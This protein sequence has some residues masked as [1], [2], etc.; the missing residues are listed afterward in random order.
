MKNFCVTLTPEV[1]SN[2]KICRFFCCC[3]SNSQAP[4]RVQRFPTFKLTCCRVLLPFGSMSLFFSCPE[5]KTN[6]EED[7][8]L[9]HQ[10]VCLS[11]DRKCPQNCGF[12]TKSPAKIINH[13][14]ECPNWEVICIWCM[15]DSYELPE[16]P[17]YASPPTPPPL[18]QQ[19]YVRRG[20]LEQHIQTHPREGKFF[21]PRPDLDLQIV[22]SRCGERGVFAEDY[23]EAQVSITDEPHFCWHERTETF[24]VPPLDPSKNPL[25]DAEGQAAPQND[26][27][28]FPSISS[29]SS[30]FQF[31]TRL[32][33]KLHSNIYL[34]AVLMLRWITVTCN[35]GHVFI[36][37]VLL[38]RT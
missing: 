23:R 18:P 36:R 37:G 14:Q 3:F 17:G 8:R 1:S 13:L 9:D 12:S 4:A 26:K 29:I 6:V 20:Q 2:S 10:L 21:I 31:S 19:A 16:W 25:P 38:W 28:F 34:A 15:L 5:C 32:L 27:V 35:L 24:K 22:C 11:R 7:D 30:I 33:L